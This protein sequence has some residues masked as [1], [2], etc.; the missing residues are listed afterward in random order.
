[1]MKI[2]KHILVA[3]TIAVSL[4]T[5]S[6]ASN[7]HDA[8]ETYILVAANTRIPYWQSALAGLNRAGKEMKVT[9]NMVGPKRYDP[10]AERDELLNAI[11]EKPSG[12]LISA[13]DATLTPDIDSAAQQGIPIITI[14]S[15]APQS[16]RLFFIGSDN[17]AIGKLGGELRCQIAGWQGEHRDVHISQPE[18]LD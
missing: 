11:Q 7:P 3:V 4:I 12:I 2:M 17:Y 1:M 9:V 18:Q 15:D 5:V 10:K 16:K 13:A 6:C 14:D 8:R